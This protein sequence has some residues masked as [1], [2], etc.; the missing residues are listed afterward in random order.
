MDR[1]IVILALEDPGLGRSWP[2]KI[3]AVEEI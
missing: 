2:W 1:I 3:L